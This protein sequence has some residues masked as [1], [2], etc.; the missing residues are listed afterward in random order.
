M[1]LALHAYLKKDLDMKKTVIL[2]LTLSFLLFGGACFTPL[3]Y[4]NQKNY[5]TE[6]VSSFLITEDNQKLIVIGKEYHYIFDA[7]Q[8]L[9][10]ISR[11]SASEKKSIRVSFSSFNIKKDQSLSGS[12]TFK[13]SQPLKPK[14][15]K[16]LLAHGFTPHSAIKN[17]LI[18]KGNLNGTRYLI[19]ELKI[20]TAMKL[21]KTYQISM[22]EEQVLTASEVTKRIL[23]TPLA[24]TA[25]GLIILGGIPIGL[26]ILAFD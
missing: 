11:A 16:Q 26:L 19:N 8:T 4:E 23:L 12:Y 9:K 14:F 22:I 6:E 24:L 5:F 25:D 15:K 1:V 3:V 21:S 13:T 2:L 17:L 7:H 10:F 18:Y 20:P